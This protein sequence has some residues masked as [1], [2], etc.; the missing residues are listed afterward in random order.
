MPT[1]IG[2]IKHRSTIVIQVRFLIHIIS[3]SNIQLSTGKLFLRQNVERTFRPCLASF[4]RRVMEIMIIAP[5]NQMQYRVVSIQKGHFGFIH[6]CA[7]T[8]SDLGWSIIIAWTQRGEFLADGDFA[9][10]QKTLR[11]TGG[12]FSSTSCLI[13][14]KPVQTMCL[15]R[16]PQGCS[17]T[18][19]PATRNPTVWHG[20]FSGS[21][22]PVASVFR[23]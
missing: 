3:P 21:D 8:M 2:E 22:S 19:C 11:T 16:F 20:A 23:T 7:S 9:A 4:S 1:G 14:E 10:E 13:Q 12:I 17:T 18:N 5:G 6:I 15:I